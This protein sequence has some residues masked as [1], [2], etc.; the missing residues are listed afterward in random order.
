MP[1]VDE[2]EDVTEKYRPEW[3]DRFEAGAVRHPHLE[4]HDGDD[5]RDDAVAE[6][7]ETAF[8]HASV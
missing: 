2:A 7:F 5:D 8:G 6:G 3:R 4:N 1:T